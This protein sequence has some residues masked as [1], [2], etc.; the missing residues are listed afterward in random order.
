MTGNP[1]KW[2]AIKYFKPREFDDPLHP[3]SGESISG[4]VLF[5]LV[6][7]RIETGWPIRTHWEMGGCVDVDGSHGHSGN[8]YHLLENGAEAVDF[9]FLSEDGKRLCDAHPR[10]Q[11]AKVEQ[12]R[13]GG[14]GVYYDWKWNNKALPIGFHVDP[15]P[16]E[17]MQRWK[18][19]KGEYIYLLGRN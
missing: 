12:M 11:Y 5:L 17:R 7:L 2:S 6:E 10:M 15:R 19:V 14:I 4:R 18:R 3:G 16:V 1:I 13:F 9:H 8:S